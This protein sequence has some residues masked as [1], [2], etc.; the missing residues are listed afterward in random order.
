[1]SSIHTTKNY[2]SHGGDELVIGGRITFLDGAEV[3]NFPGNSEGGGS[4]ALPAAYVADSEA[5]TVAS[6]KTDFNSL[7]AVLREAGLLSATTP[8]SDEDENAGGS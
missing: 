7:L 8:D 2:F 1:M 6:L 5:T 4:S 3:V